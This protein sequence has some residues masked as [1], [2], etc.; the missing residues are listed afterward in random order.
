MVLIFGQ[1]DNFVHGFYPYLLWEL[2]LEC[3]S[4]TVRLMAAAWLQAC[5]DVFLDGHAYVHFKKKAMHLS[6]FDLIICCVYK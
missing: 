5:K 4:Q 1:M 3:K 6:L 2:L